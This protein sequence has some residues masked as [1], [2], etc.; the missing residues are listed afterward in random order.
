MAEEKKKYR[1]EKMRERVD[2]INHLDMEKKEIQD[3]L[4]EKEK[5]LYKYKFKIKDL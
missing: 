1:E 2:E 3:Q 5:E 4:K